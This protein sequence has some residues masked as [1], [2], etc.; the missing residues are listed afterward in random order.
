MYFSFQEGRL[1]EGKPRKV[2]SE[3]EW[4]LQNGRGS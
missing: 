3:V 2:E 1:K 4:V